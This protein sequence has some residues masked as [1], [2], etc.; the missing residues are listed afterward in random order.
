VVPIVWRYFPFTFLPV[1]R[2]RL[3]PPGRA[4]AQRT[5]WSSPL[6]G[7]FLFCGMCAA[8][9]IAR[10]HYKAA[11]QVT[12][13]QLGLGNAQKDSLAPKRSLPLGAKR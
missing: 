9:D 6:L 1:D 13:S 8:G 10:G 11:L 5:R 7:R 12:R 3:S 4:G 2:D